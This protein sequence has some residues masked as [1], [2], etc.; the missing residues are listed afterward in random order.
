[1]HKRIQEFLS[2]RDHKYIDIIDKK[3]KEVKKEV[4]LKVEFERVMTISFSF[5]PS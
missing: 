1:M 3:V 2:E 4:E 5:S